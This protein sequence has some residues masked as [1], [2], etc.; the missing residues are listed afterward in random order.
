MV[1]DDQDTVGFE[2]PDQLVEHGGRVYFR[3]VVIFGIDPVQVVVDLDDQHGIE[4]SVGNVH[5]VQ[6]DC[7]VLDIGQ[8]VVGDPPLPR[9]VGPAVEGR[10]VDQQHVSFRAYD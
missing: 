4:R 8:P 9:V 3:P 5:V 2:C 7:L 1:D 6:V 10:I